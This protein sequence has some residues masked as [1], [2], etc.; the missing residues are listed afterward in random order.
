MDSGIN[1]I[2]MGEGGRSILMAQFMKDTGVII[3]HMGKGE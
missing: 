1:K 2:V 3:Y